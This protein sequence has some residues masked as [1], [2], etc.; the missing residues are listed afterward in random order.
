MPVV[1]CVWD[2]NGW[3]K[4]PTQFRLFCRHPVSK[5]LVEKNIEVHIDTTL[6]ETVAKA[7]K[8]SIYKLGIVSLF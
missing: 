1:A 7:H 2:R 4:F 5:E 3:T 6:S 8:V